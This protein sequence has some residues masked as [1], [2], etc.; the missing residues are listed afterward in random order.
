MTTVGNILTLKSSEIWSIAPDSSVFEALEMMAD[1]NVSGLLILENEKLVGI[2]TERDYARKLILKGKFSKKTKVSELMTKNILYVEPDNTLKDCMTLM[3]NKRIRH[4][5]VLDN[6]RLVGILTIGD[7]V[8]LII[9]EQ[10]T[11]IHQLENYIS[12][13]Y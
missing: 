6:G 2:F 1:K 11:T 10:K 5:P 4:L 8:K 13:G 7:L 9:S 3:T 12:G